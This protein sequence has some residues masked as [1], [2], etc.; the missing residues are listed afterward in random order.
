MMERA[1]ILVQQKEIERLRSQLDNSMPLSIKFGSFNCNQLCVYVN[2]VEDVSGCICNNCVV[3]KYDEG[4]TYVQSEEI[5]EIM[6]LLGLKEGSKIKLIYDYKSPV[7]IEVTYRVWVKNMYINMRMSD[8]IA[9]EMFRQ[10]VVRVPNIRR[11][12][13]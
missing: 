2:G 3:L 11:E 12:P 8:K 5:K 7:E 9:L 13:M 1:I 10:L 6:L 4:T